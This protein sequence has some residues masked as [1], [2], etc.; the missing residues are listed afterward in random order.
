MT[1][2]VLKDGTSLVTGGHYLVKHENNKRAVRRIFM[3]DERRFDSIL[4]FVFSSKADKRTTL[5]RKGDTYYWKGIKLPQSEIS[6][7]Y[8]DLLECKLING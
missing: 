6:I 5:T 1:N 4:C 8:Y 2:H 7:P 3:Y